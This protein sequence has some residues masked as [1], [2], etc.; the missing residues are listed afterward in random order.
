MIQQL[1]LLV[2]LFACHWV[3]DFTHASRP[4]ML[5]AK[6]FGTPQLPIAAHALV[7][8]AL[9]GLA[10]LAFLKPQHA[11]VAFVVQFVTHFV[12][13]LLKGRVSAWVPSVRDP[14]GYPYWYVFGA[15]QFAHAIV[16]ILTVTLIYTIPA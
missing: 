13:D 14:K 8:A 3:G 5:K 11:L 12:I 2:V 10:V 15:D 9:M 1:Q 4:W 6:Q 7:H 16:I